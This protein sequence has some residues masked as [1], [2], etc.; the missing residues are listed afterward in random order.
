M[1]HIPYK[2]GAQAV[3]DLV[4]GQVHVYLGSIASMG[5]F[6]NSGRLKALAI[7]GQSRAPALP[8]V[9]TFSESGLP[10]F[11]IKLWYGVLAPFGTPPTIV[12]KMSAAVSRIV[13]SADFK[14]TI[15]GLGIT[16]YNVPREQIVEMMRA[17][18]T[19]YAEVIRSAKIVPN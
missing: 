16:P 10:G 7:T 14:D 9:P 18:T 5:A 3:T 19:R 15:L 8:Q 12:D 4:A 13:T 17:E 11:D 6:I 2:G 1:T